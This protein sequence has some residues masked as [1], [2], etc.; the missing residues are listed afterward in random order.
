M[1]QLTTEIDSSGNTSTMTTLTVQD[2]AD[3]TTRKSPLYQKVLGTAVFLSFFMAC[4]TCLVIP[5]PSESINSQE[6][7]LLVDQGMNDLLDA[8]SVP[9]SVRI[10][11][12]F[13]WPNGL[14]VVDAWTALPWFRQLH[15]HRLVTM[16]W[17]IVAPLQLA[18]LGGIRLYN[19]TWHQRMG[20]LFTGCSSCIALGLME[21]IY[22]RR[23]Y[24][25]PHWLAMVIN[26]AKVTYFVTSLLLALGWS[27]PP[28][29]K[30]TKI[31]QQNHKVWI[32]RHVTMGYT[33]AFQRF[34]MFVVGPILYAMLRM[35]QIPGNELNRMLTS[36]EMQQWYNVTSIVSVIIPFVLVEKFVIQHPFFLNLGI[37]KSSY[38]RKRD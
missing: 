3:A 6:K 5:I 13:S 25:Q 17:L 2:H 32:L 18:S 33:V 14:P 12:N 21:I 31:Y 26:I 9:V 4:I 24:G 30:G 29:R 34:L 36:I 15:T 27:W 23:V 8:L 16:T 35:V 10:M 1:K 19:R 22:R 38:I 28:L 37:T 20:F 7:V 11:T